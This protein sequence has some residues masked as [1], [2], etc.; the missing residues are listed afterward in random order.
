MQVLR[1]QDAGALRLPFLSS[2]FGTLWAL[3]GEVVEVAREF[4]LRLT[5]RDRLES[6]QEAGQE[7]RRMAV[8]AGASSGR[9]GVRVRSERG[10]PAFFSSV[11]HNQLASWQLG[12]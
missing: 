6:E 1:R 10:Q 2:F 9:T 3:D 8:A 11:S 5:W 7:E 4:L 12:S